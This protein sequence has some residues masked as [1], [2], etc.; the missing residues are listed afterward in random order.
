MYYYATLLSI[1]TIYTFHWSTTRIKNRTVTWKISL[2]IL[3][4]PNLHQNSNKPLTTN[5]ITPPPKKHNLS[6]HRNLQITMTNYFS[7][8]KTTS[9]SMLQ[10][11]HFYHSNAMPAP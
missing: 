9:L 7:S 8:F 4:L 10:N 3:P 2:I 6:D 5:K 11:C 1:C